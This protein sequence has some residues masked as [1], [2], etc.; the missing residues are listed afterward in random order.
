MYEVSTGLH[1]TLHNSL[2][3]ECLFLADEARD[4]FEQS[5]RLE[6]EALTS[7]YRISLS[8][9]SLKITIRLMYAIAWLLTQRAVA[10]GE[11]SLRDSLDPSRRINNAPVTDQVSI[12]ALP[13]TARKIIDA[14]IDIYERVSSL[15]RSLDQGMT[16]TS[17]ALLL[18]QRLAWALSYSGILN[19]LNR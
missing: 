13:A 18:Q 17:P 1:R 9:E 7:E 16:S 15:D 4:Y 5:G 19:E 10:T 3:T 6:R 2:Y 12:T 8:C 14:S 11:L